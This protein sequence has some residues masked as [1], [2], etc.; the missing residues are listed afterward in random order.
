MSAIGSL[1]FCTDCGNLLDTSTGNK[2]TIL[3]C[4]CCGAENQGFFSILQ[5]LNL[6]MFTRYCFKNYHNYNKTR[7]FP[8]PSQAEAFS[9]SD[10]GAK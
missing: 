6:L 1:V 10:G 2:Q 5:I 9:Y 8:F 4:G 3:V 7:F